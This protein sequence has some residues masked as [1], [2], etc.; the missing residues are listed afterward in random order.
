MEVRTE[1]TPSAPA[2]KPCGKCGSLK[3]ETGEFRASGG[4]LSAFFD[5]ATERFNYVSCGSCGYT[6]FYNARLGTG[7]RVVD[8][9]GG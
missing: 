7:S 9:L 1:N 8:F 2:I 6:E 4:L 3:R 5:F